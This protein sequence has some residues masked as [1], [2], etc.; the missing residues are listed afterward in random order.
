M[1][2]WKRPDLPE[3]PEGE[4]ALPDGVSEVAR[5]AVEAYNAGDFSRCRA[6]IRELR[7]TGLAGV[8]AAAA[9]DLEA[10]LRPDPVVLALAAL[11]VLALVFLALWS[12]TASH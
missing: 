1:P 2:F 11:S 10:R 12:V 5:A 4:L 8:D 3:H 7:A 9:R 6:L